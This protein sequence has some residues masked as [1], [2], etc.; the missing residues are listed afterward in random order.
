MFHNTFC[1][2]EEK[3]LFLRYMYKVEKQETRGKAV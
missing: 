2:W 1:F 3:L